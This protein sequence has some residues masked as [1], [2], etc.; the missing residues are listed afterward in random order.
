MINIQ[1]DVAATKRSISP[2]AIESPKAHPSTSYQ[3]Y[4]G[5]RRDIS[6]GTVVIVMEEA[7][8][9]EVCYIEVYP[10]VIIKISGIHLTNVRCY[11]AFIVKI[12]N[13]VLV[14]MKE[15]PAGPSPALECG[16]GRPF[17]R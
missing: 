14:V 15:Q 1:I 10:S 6:E 13:A 11:P 8:A 5:L 12:L 17:T 4:A 16:Q 7:I 9:S 2:V 3:R